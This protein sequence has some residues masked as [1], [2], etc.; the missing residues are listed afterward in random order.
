MP[1]YKM[2]RYE[3][4]LMY[5]IKDYIYP[6]L[7]EPILDIGAGIDLWWKRRLPEFP[8]YDICDPKVNC[9]WEEYSIHRNYNTILMIKILEHILNPTRF[10]AKAIASLAKGGYIIIAV[11][12]AFSDHYSLAMEMGLIKSELEINKY[13][14]AQ[15]HINRFTYQN[16]IDTFV[17]CRNSNQ[18]IFTDVHI[19]WKPLPNQLCELLPLKILK[20]WVKRRSM[21]GM[22]LIGIINKVKD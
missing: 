13:D 11:P 9:K 12:N 15:G 2:T 17:R 18:C 21:N 20:A 7:K 3:R 8:D 4:L 6:Y 14:L 16:L 22:M 19:G 5:E 10:L 1:E